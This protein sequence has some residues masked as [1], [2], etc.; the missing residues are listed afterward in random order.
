MSVRVTFC[1]EAMTK[2]GRV[3]EDRLEG[4]EGGGKG[5][6][7]GRGLCKEKGVVTAVIC[8]TLKSYEA[9]LRSETGV[10]VIS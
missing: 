8:S 5:G 9:Y 6:G 7:G 4:G 3:V 2:K 10:A 1:R